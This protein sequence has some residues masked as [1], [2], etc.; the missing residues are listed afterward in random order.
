MSKPNIILLGVGHSGTTVVAEMMK[1]LG[2]NI[3]DISDPTY[4]VRNE[5]KFVV[6]LNR[7]LVDDYR[8]IRKLNEKEK[9]G[10]HV[11]ISDHIKNCFGDKDNSMVLKDPRFVITLDKWIPCIKISTLVYLKRDRDRLYH[12]FKKRGK[13]KEPNKIASNG[14][15]VDELIGMA[16]RQYEKWSGKK[17]VL[18]YE[19]VMSAISV[20]DISRNSKDNKDVGKIGI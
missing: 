8:G 11:A 12:S 19:D 3:P 16:D 6:V 13:C 2:W 18:N 17:I 15:T 14:M 7:L 9:S 20:F 4:G 1:R 10:V 5:P